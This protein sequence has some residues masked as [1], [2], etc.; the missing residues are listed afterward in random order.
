MFSKKKTPRENVLIL[1]LGGIGFYLAK[2]L[3]HEGYAITAIESDQKLI[4]YADSKIDARLVVGDAMS[5]D[6]WREAA[7]EKMDLLISVTNN[8]AVNMMAAMIGDKFG[9]KQKI[10]RVRSLDFGE[11]DSI[12]TAEQLKI[13]LL[14]H[15]EELAAQEI[16]MLIQRTAGNEIVDIA[17]GQ[18][19]V[20][21]TRID[22]T[23]PLVNKDL[24]T[25]SQIY[26]N[27]SFRVVAIARGI[28]TIIPGGNN[29]I[30]PQ[31][32][33]LIMADSKDLPHLMELTGI[34]QQQ[35]YRVLILGGGLVGS[36]VAQIL[37]K[38]VKVKLIEKDAAKAAE[39]SSLLPD[40][41]VLHG[42]GSDKE[43][44]EM[45]GLKEMDIFISAT[46]E[47]ETNIMSCL[48]AKHMMGTMNG[49]LQDRERKTIALVNKEEYLVLAATSGS[50]IALN[51][52]ILAG[53]EIVSFIRQ[54]ELLSI[55]H[56]HGFGIEVVELIAAENS[57]ITRKPLAR[58]A[59]SFAGK[60]IVGSVYRNGDWQT[61]VGDTHI[62]AGE[63]AIAICTSEHLKDVRELFL[64]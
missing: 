62:Q 15:P 34:K 18:I 5:I 64:L 25:L 11:P 28:T 30:L 63:K 35:L 42:D 58:L 3:L 43:V 61:A 13:D 44:L 7:A 2:R 14:I 16:V 20:M 24:K 40:T 47:N 33:V 39:L 21:A 37:G 32:Q 49:G 26:N 51:K 4:Q 10:A 52:K 59:P 46:G 38:T 45:A 8:D 22:E 48:L 27:Y 56:M 6:C 57:V 36:R 53:H 12:L 23:S 19:Q 60:I 17:Q 41:E 54:G 55:S 50:D 1:G 29:M 9:I 31:D